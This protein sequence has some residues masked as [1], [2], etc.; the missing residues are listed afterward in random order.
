MKTQIYIGRWSF[1]TCRF[2]YSCSASFGPLFLMISYSQ[3]Y[4]DSTPTLSLCL[5]LSLFVFLDISLSL[6]GLAL[7]AAQSLTHWY[8]SRSAERENERRMQMGKIK[9]SAGRKMPSSLKQHLLPSAASARQLNR[10]KPIRPATFS[11]SST[12]GGC[13]YV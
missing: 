5:Y 11:S 1:I 13:V 6:R 10:Y 12:G 7:T 2:S 9:H 8:V 4:C 3:E